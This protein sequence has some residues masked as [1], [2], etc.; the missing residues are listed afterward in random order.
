MERNEALKKKISLN[1]DKSGWVYFLLAECSSVLAIFSSAVIFLCFVSFHGRKRN[2][3]PSDKTKIIQQ[4]K[5]LLPGNAGVTEVR[6]A[7]P[8]PKIKIPNNFPLSGGI[9]QQSMESAMDGAE[10]GY[11]E[12]FRTINRQKQNLFKIRQ[13]LI[14]LFTDIYNYKL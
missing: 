11:G 14:V 7:T 10:R 9:R 12:S 6:I 1:S 4:L 2:E 8:D 5:W 3:N 13:A